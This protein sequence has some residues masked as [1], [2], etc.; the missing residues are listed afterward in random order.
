M[1][2]DRSI[3][4]SVNSILWNE[5]TTEIK[6]DGNNKMT[7]TYSDL[8]GGQD[9]II[10]EDEDTLDWLDGNIDADPLFPGTGDLPYMLVYE[11][12]CRNAGTPDTTGLFLPLN[13]LAGGPRVWEDRI[14]MGAY[15]WNNLDIYESAVNGRRSAIRIYPNPLKDITT[16]EYELQAPVMVS[17]LIF[18]HLGQQVAM[19]VN[20]QQD[21]GKH[22]FTWS[23]EGLP[24]G[25][26]FYRLTAGRQSL[27][28][29]MIVVR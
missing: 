15:E 20:E 16:F 8:R 10:P 7:F 24:S 2:I 1:C 11:S 19:L 29:K 14:D 4:T 13:D 9:G 18:N 28:G 21:K 25:I 6:S 23:A 26:Y 12:P 5:N 3:L 17:L 27:T 22:V